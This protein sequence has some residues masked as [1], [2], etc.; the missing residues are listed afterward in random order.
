LNSSEP[1]L[2][3]PIPVKVY[4]EANEE[5]ILTLI[6]SAPMDGHINLVIIGAVTKAIVDR[7]NSDLA[8]GV[9][10]GYL[11]I[12]NEKNQQEPQSIF[13]K[14]FFYQDYEFAFKEVVEFGMG[15]G[16]AIYRQKFLRQKISQ[17]IANDA[18]D[19]G[20]NEKEAFV[21][22][23]EKDYTETP[24]VV[25]WEKKTDT[26]WVIPGEAV[27]FWSNILVNESD[28]GCSLAKELYQAFHSSDKQATKKL[29]SAIESLLLHGE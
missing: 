16:M 21:K 4:D 9:G 19:W 29:S 26:T 1:F 28:K 12:M 27:K 20:L 3:D 5:R 25:F 23:K 11:N 7:L 8:A 2:T 6:F 17:V 18:I 15:L 22:A 13:I 24:G 14:E 10:T